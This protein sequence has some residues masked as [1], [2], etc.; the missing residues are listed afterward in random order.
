MPVPIEQQA[1]DALALLDSLGI[2]KAHFAGQS[3]GGLIS[4]EVA[5]ESLDRVQS[6]AVIEPP[7]PNV[8]FQSRELA[9]LAQQ[10]IGLYADGQGREAVEL[11]A[12]AVIGEEV[13][14]EFAKDWLERWYPDA[15]VIFESDLP[16]HAE[17]SFGAEDASKIGGVPV[18]NLYGSQTPEGFQACA[19]GERVVPAG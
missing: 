4:L 19:R 2:S 7:V 13:F 11:F 14:P 15:K 3:Y 16:A 5:L 6:L 17:W 18:L 8:L 10:A 9:E 1:A 12:R